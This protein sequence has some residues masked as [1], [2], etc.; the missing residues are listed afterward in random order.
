VQPHAP[1]EID[2]DNRLARARE[3]PI[4]DL[5]LPARRSIVARSRPSLTFGTASSTL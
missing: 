4:R 1:A 3:E 5:G 2:R